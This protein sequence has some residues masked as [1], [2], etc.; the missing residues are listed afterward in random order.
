MLCMQDM[1]AALATA[2]QRTRALWAKEA[3][4]RERALQQVDTSWEARKAA[5]ELGQEL[6]EAYQ[7]LYATERELE[8]VSR[9]NQENADIATAAIQ[10]IVDTKVPHLPSC[11]LLIGA[12]LS[13]G[14]SVPASTNE[15]RGAPRCAASFPEQ[16]RLDEGGMRAEVDAGGNWRHA[17][18]AGRP[19]QQSGSSC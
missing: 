1:E 15:L 9:S 10:L 4:W 6:S 17:L 16:I 19:A 12:A 11:C 3:F 14:R 5:T 2:E 8:D 7:R 18:P 13:A